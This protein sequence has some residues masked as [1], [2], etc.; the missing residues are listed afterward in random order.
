MKVDIFSILKRHKKATDGRLSLTELKQGYTDIESL[1][2]QISTAVF[3]RLAG[4]V[5]HFSMADLWEPADGYTAMGRHITRRDCGEGSGRSRE[6]LLLCDVWFT[7]VPLSPFLLGRI[8]T[9]VPVPLA[10]MQ[11]L[12]WCS[13]PSSPRV[14]TM[15]LDFNVFN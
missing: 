10:R 1:L 4:S 5:A 13:S 6:A 3:T 2:A 14:L 15:I 9:A 12:C 7:H 8:P 11:P